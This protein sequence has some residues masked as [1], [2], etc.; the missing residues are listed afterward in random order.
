MNGS[1]FLLAFLISLRIVYNHSAT[2][3]SILYTNYLIPPSE[4]LNGFI[5]TF[6]RCFVRPNSDNFS[7]GRKSGRQSQFTA[8]NIH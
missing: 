8:S 6:M 2:S 7:G 4:V 3:K 5:L 1:L